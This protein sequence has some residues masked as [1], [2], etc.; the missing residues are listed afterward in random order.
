[1]NPE[2]NNIY[3]IEGP[4]EIA[5]MKELLK[6]HRQ[7]HSE[8]IAWCKSQ[9]GSNAIIKRSDMVGMLASPDAK[10]AE[11]WKPINKP[12]WDFP[13]NKSYIPD[14]RT[15]SGKKLRQEMSSK[16]TLPNSAFAEALGQ[17]K[18]I[19][20]WSEGAC[21]MMSSQCYQEGKNLV[22]IIPKDEKN[23]KPPKVAGCRLLR[24]SEYYAI[25]ESSK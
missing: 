19:V 25:K 1:M 6:K 5:K 8:R 15:K 18:C 2:D 10:I 17:Q 4:N 23:D 7:L 16:K 11:G 9:G 12:D 3:L 21:R 13:P 24:T 22:L 20:R 14:G